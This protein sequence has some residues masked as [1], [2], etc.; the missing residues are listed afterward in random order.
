MPKFVTF[1][2]CPAPVSITYAPAMNN[3]TCDDC[4]T[5]YYPEAVANA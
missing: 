2:K 4:G 3:Y 1:D 5:L